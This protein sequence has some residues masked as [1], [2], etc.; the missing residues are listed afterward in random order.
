MANKEFIMDHEVY[1]WAVTGFQLPIAKDITYII[2]NFHEE[3]EAYRYANKLSIRGWTI[4]V[5]KQ[6]IWS[7]ADQPAAPEAKIIK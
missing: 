5:S 1:I 3:P 4:V 7:L 6:R 2:E